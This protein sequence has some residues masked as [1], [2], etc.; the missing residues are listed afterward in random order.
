MTHSSCLCCMHSVALQF[1]KYSF[2]YAKVERML[3]DLK[4]QRSCTKEVQLKMLLLLKEHPELLAM[5][6]NLVPVEYQLP[7]P[8]QKDDLVSRTVEFE[9]AVNFVS[10]VKEECMHDKTRYT[11]FLDLMT[12]YHHTEES[13]MVVYE[14][15]CRLFHYRP[16][17]VA[18]LGKFLL[19]Y[20]TRWLQRRFTRVS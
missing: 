9:E 8:V 19:N 20:Q 6:Y 7:M 14:E 13:V 11:A 12:V 17:L 18:E 16:D 4:A 1:G 10:K 2:E 3:K 5:F 15:L